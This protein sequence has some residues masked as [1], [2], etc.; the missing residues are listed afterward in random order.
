LFRS[1]IST[2]QTVAEFILLVYEKLAML[3]GILVQY[4]F[5]FPSRHAIPLTCCALQVAVFNLEGEVISE[6]AHVVFLFS[7]LYKF[8]LCMRLL[9]YAVDGS[10]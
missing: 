10:A 4:M 5:A 8:D 9:V 2:Q 1:R 6:I 7:V 3:C